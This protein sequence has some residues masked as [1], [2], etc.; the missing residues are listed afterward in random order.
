[1]GLLLLIVAI[2]FLVFLSKSFSPEHLGYLGERKVSSILSKLPED[3]YKIINN[4]LIKSG[5]QTTQIDHVVVSKYGIFVIETK[6][7][8]GWI[9]GYENSEYWIKNMYGYKYKFY[10]PIKQNK[11]HIVALSNELDIALDKFISIVVFL[12]DAELKIKTSQNV[13]YSSQVNDLIQS[14]TK[15]KFTD[16]LTLA[17]FNAIVSF[18]ITEEKEREQHTFNTKNLVE[19]KETL[20]QHGICPKCGHSLSLKKGKYGYF[21]GCDNYPNCKYT[22]PYDDFEN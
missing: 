14:Y 9:Q 21:I 5:N 20:I 16:N 22:Q 11:R 7:Y 15:V 8:S 3:D 2:F 18:N 4:L 13:I 1:M 12:D 10:N 6:N 19:N 17:I